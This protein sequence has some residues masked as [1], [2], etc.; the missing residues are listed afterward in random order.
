MKTKNLVILTSLLML[1]FTSII[2]QVEWVEFNG[3]LPEGAVIGGVETNRSLA[4]CRATYQGATHPGKVVERK[5][6]IGYGGKEVELKRF[7]V[8]VNKGLVELDWIKED[9]G[10]PK[11]AI[12]AGEEKGLSLYVGRAYHEKGTH[13]GKVFKVGKNSICNFGYAG[14]EITQNSYEV[15]VQNEP[16]S[17]QKRMANDDRC[18]TKTPAVAGVYIGTMSKESR[19]NEGQS[20]ISNNTKFQTRVTDDGRLVVEEILDR[21]LCD[22]GRVLVFK[23]NEIWSNTKAAQDPS[24]DYYLKFQEDGNLCIYSEQKGFVWCSMSNGI[25]G[26]HFELT[27]TGHLEIVNDHGGEVWP[28]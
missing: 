6:N 20:L 14:K 24:L 5:C 1:S 10:I 19:L 16:D 27:N 25:N 11:N 18:G 2:A 28:D 21:V 17:N 4:V 13:P 23:S 26:H 15:L 12:K 3:E 22:D 9:G 8:L 7:D